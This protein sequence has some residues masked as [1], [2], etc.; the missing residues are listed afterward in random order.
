MAAC[1]KWDQSI[2]GPKINVQA[3][4]QSLE[5]VFEKPLHAAPLQQRYSIR[6]TYKRG[7]S[8]LLANTLSRST[9]LT[10]N[11]LKQSNFE[12]FRLDIDHHLQNPRITSQMLEDIKDWIN[13]I[14]PFVNSPRSSSKAGF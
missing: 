2:Y 13:R 8:F 12:I 9:L 14:L 10:T 11:D 3:D 1:D 7:T 4:H 5:T 6:V